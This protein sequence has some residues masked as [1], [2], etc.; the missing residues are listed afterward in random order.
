M[1][2]RLN[3][4]QLPADGGDLP[5]ASRRAEPPEES[6]ALSEESLDEIEQARRDLMLAVLEAMG[7]DCADDVTDAGASVESGPSGSDVS[8]ES[9]ASG[10]ASAGSE[11][12]RPEDDGISDSTMDLPEPT[13]PPA[14]PAEAADRL[15]ESEAVG[16]P[17][18]AV[19]VEHIDC[20]GPSP[21]RR[22]SPTAEH[23]PFAGP[24]AG[25]SVVI[26]HALTDE[27]LEPYFAGT[28]IQS[29]AIL[30]EAL[31]RTSS[32]E[33]VPTGGIDSQGPTDNDRPVPASMTQSDSELLGD[34]MSEIVRQDI[35]AYRHRFAK[36]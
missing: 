20:V 22:C 21:D 18:D 2:S 30:E 9:H 28:S 10:S 15:A 24:D 35:A 3:R 32:G 5:A 26:H 13:P 7:A 23:C 4:T 16:A 29:D 36:E 31:E 6:W 12:S 33:G 11:D 34:I 8:D 19:L 1:F 27:P 17:V 25:G 14:R